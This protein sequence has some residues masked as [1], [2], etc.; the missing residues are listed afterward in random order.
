MAKGGGGSR[1]MGP[2][3]SKIRNYIQPKI[4]IFFKENKIDG[5]K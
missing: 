4:G 5:I 1:V 3:Y 2:T